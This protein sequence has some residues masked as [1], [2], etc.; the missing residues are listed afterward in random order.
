MAEG[1]GSAAPARTAL[2]TGGAHRIGQAVSLAL[3]RA[4]F[5]VVIHARQ[6]SD[7]ANALAAEIASNGVG[8]AIVLA[9]LADHAAVAAMVPQAVKAAGPLTL[10]VNNASEFADDEIG[11]LDHAQWDRHFAVNLRAP[12]FLAQAFAAQAP[13][14]Q[15]A[16]IVN[17]TDQRARKPVPRQFS[18]TLTKCALHAATTTLAQA[19]APRIRVNAVAPGPTLPSPRQDP[20]AFAQQAAALP[21]GHG[22]RP[23]D[24]AAAVVYLASARRVTG[25]TIAVD[26]G[27]HIAWKTPDVWGVEE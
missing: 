14:G 22:P 11:S 15:D 20:A 12:I 19:L 10:L 21:L 27:Q 17:I 9:D 13:R 18:Y 16:C 4:G 8:A 26:G 24:I 3:A 2:V 7:E 6:M 5:G 1:S 25:E 23:Q